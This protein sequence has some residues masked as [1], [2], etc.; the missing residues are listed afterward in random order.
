MVPRVQSGG[1]LSPNVLA[2]QI[3]RLEPTCTG[4]RNRTADPGPQPASSE[5]ANGFVDRVRRQ[6]RDHA[7][8]HVEGRFQVGL[9]DLT[10]LPDESAAGCWTPCR[11]VDL[12]S[13]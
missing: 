2:E 5:E 6:H 7:N 9:G 12:H 13:T 10:E 3:Y 8:A 11:T 4:S 1:T